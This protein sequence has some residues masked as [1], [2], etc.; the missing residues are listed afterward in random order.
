MSQKKALVVDDS[1]VTRMMISKI[2]RETNPNTEIFEAQSA[3]MAKTMIETLPNLDLITLDQNMPGE[4]SGLDLAADLVQKY[5]KTRIF[6]VTANIQD[7]IR[8][9][10]NLLG[11][12]FIEKPVTSEKL[13][14]I[15]S[16]LL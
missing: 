10:A 5:E 11:I 6:L 14:P 16:K 7:A 9:K 13:N 3:D 1:I 12:G 4:I 8:N 15:L 2:I